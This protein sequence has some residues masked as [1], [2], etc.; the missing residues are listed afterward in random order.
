MTVYLEG[1]KKTST[2]VRLEEI[3]VQT[4]DNETGLATERQE[5]RGIY[6]SEIGLASQRLGNERQEGLCKQIHVH[7]AALPGEGQ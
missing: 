7:Q 1:C 2:H 5:P 3:D 4:M 6:F